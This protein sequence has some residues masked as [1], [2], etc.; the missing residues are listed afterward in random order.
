MKSLWNY[1]RSMKFAI[2]L[3]FLLL[4]TNIPTIWI[5]QHSESSDKVFKFYIEH[6][7]LAN[8]FNKLQLFDI[9]SSIIFISIYILLIISLIGCLIPRTYTY[10]NLIRNKSYKSISKINK[11]LYLYK[12]IEIPNDQI[13]QYE[14]ELKL[15]KYKLI[16]NYGYKGILIRE[17]GNLCFHYGLILTI[18]LIFISNMYSYKGIFTLSTGSRFINVPLSYDNFQHGKLYNIKNIDN[19][20]FTLNK[21]NASYTKK[22]QKGTPLYYKAHITY[23]NKKKIITVNNPL[24]VNNTKI[25]LQSHGYGIQLNNNNNNINTLCIPLDNN[26]LS[27]CKFKISDNILGI[28]SFYPTYKNYESIF[29]ATNNPLLNT[30]FYKSRIPITNLNNINPMQLQQIKDNDKLN[31]MLRPGESINLENIGTIKF[32]KYFDYVSF[33][34]SHDPTRAYLLLSIIMILI[35]ISLSIFTPCYILHK[36]QHKSYTKYKIRYSKRT[37]L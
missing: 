22:I 1:L 32:T 28:A 6:K 34:V 29:P 36:E 24:K 14:N 27:R 20:N 18:I 4:L 30:S 9:H 3:L 26:L 16:N 19:I 25:Y 11:N 33:K 23:K 15:K 7:T 10:I 13:E 21:F 12:N 8:I 37:G 35:G 2:I 5:P 17:F 31:F